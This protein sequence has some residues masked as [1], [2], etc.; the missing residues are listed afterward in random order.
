LVVIKLLDI[1]ARVDAAV[2]H[3]VAFNGSVVVRK[4]L[5]VVYD[6]AVVD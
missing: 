4:Y 2:T 5:H 3:T 1:V 6:L